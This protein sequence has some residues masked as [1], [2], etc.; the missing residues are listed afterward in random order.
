MNENE[1]YIFFSQFGEVI[2]AKLARNYYGTLLDYTKQAKLEVKYNLEKKKN[3]L[4]GHRFQKK[5]EKIQRR[6]QNLKTSTEKK[7]QKE[8]NHVPKVFSFNFV[9]L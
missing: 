4:N 9:N 6:I 8:F 1:I 2:E 3:D 5:L 7:L